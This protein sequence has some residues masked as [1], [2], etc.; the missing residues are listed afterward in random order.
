MSHV[1]AVYRCL[2]AECVG[3]FDE[4]TQLKSKLDFVLLGQDKHAGANRRQYAFVDKPS[5]RAFV[6]LADHQIM[7]RQRS[8]A[9]E[10]R[11]LVI[12]GTATRKDGFER[13]RSTGCSPDD[14]ALQ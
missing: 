3:Q 14:F 5:H 4:A 2:S 7:F 1:V 8:T 9:P 12:Y 6:L 13:H 10:F 11:I